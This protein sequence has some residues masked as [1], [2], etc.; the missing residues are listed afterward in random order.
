MEE[1]N[2]AA[3]EDEQ[4][5]D[6]VPHK[7]IR[8]RKKQLYKAIR[9]QVEF[10][11][12]DAN[13]AKDRFL[14]NLIAEDPYVDISVIM[15]CNKIRALTTDVKDICGALRYSDLLSVTEDGTKVFRTTPVKE[16]NNTDDCTIYVE[17]LP[18]DAQHEWLKE[19]FSAYGKVAYVSLPKYRSSGKIKGFAFVEFDTPE[20]ANKTLEAFGARGC[21]LS[22][23]IAP[24]KLCSISTY[25]P[26]EVKSENVPSEKIGDSEESQLQD[27]LLRKKK[28]RKKEKQE[29]GTELN[30]KGSEVL[31]TEKKKEV[32]MSAKKCNRKRIQGT[33]MEAVETGQ[34]Q[35]EDDSPP[36]KTKKRKRTEEP[37]VEGTEGNTDI[38]PQ[39]HESEKCL[40]KKNRKRKNVEA[41]EAVVSEHQQVSSDVEHENEGVVKRKK[42]KLE[43]WDGELVDEIGTEEGVEDVVKKKTRK[44]R[45]KHMKDKQDIEA[46]RLQILSKQE[47]KHLRNKY[48][49]LQRQKMACL[50]QY[51]GRNRW[52]SNPQF[53]H[54]DRLQ[55]ANGHN[56]E[57]EHH[58]NESTDMEASVKQETEKEPRFT[59]TPG[60]IVHAVLDEPVV[61]VRKFKADAKALGDVEYVDVIMGTNEAFLRCST[62]AAAEQLVSSA[63]WQQV[64]IL[65]GK[66]ESQYWAKII[67]DREQK[68]SNNIRAKHRGRDKILRRAERE[69]GK[70]IRFD[71]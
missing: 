40:E 41:E 46:S 42:M 19:V 62:A 7:K 47:W 60:V 25:G 27:K 8:H 32:A 6:E 12:S 5:Q 26:D 58:G 69:L 4:R 56:H 55:P 24:E 23:Q 20:E 57:E 54:Q 63:P 22:S 45:K 51:L 18:L 3:L 52:N 38:I 39:S 53:Q 17:Q 1:E 50:K 70:H 35:P 44:R 68:L 34:S 30:I 16:K 10:Y 29:R 71:D 43:E 37:G 49:N 67:S 14:G 2:S 59:F 66:D 11:F 28:K 36:L 13:L 33:E 61:E 9:N 31:Q 64:E 65:K 15:Q 21:R 48:L